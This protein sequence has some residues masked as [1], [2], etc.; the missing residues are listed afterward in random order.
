MI[1]DDVPER[2]ALVNEIVFVNMNERVTPRIERLTRAG[3]PLV[4]SLVLFLTSSC[5]V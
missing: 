4:F 5:K 1:N 2:L 3:P